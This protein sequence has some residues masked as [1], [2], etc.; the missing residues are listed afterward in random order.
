MMIKIESDPYIRAFMKQ[1]E[2]QAK[3]QCAPLFWTDLEG[4]PHNGSMTFLRTPERLVGITNKHVAEAISHLTHDSGVIV[5]L[6]AA[7]FDPHRLIDCHPDLDLASYDI[8]DVLLSTAGHAAGTVIHWPIALPSE[9]DVLVVGG[10]P[11]E[12][13]QSKEGGT[14]DFGFLWVAGQSTVF[15]TGTF[16]SNLD[17]KTV[18][19]FLNSLPLPAQ[20]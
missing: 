8:S 9:T 13:R 1:Y 14:V 20:T 19:Q 2:Q 15:R 18:L 11:A 12:F 5:Q 10:W 3:A 16:P 17:L 4:N 7:Q 6:G